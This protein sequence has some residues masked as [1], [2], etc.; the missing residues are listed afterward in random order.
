MVAEVVANA[1][2]EQIHKEF[3]NKKKET[4]IKSYFVSLNTRH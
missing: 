4:S 2:Y 3:E 1:P